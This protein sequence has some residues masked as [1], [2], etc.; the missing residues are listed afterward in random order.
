MKRTK[1]KKKCENPRCGKFF[2][3]KNSGR[4]LCYECKK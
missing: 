1:F 3:P 2:I 4:R